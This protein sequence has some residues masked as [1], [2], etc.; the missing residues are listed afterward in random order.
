VNDGQYYYWPGCDFDADMIAALDFMRGASGAEQPFFCLQEPPC[1]LAFSIFRDN[2]QLSCGVFFPKPGEEWD[3]AVAIDEFA[4][5]QSAA[6]FLKSR[7]DIPRFSIRRPHIFVCPNE[8]GGYDYI[9][10]K[11]EGGN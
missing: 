7:D 11:A 3:T 5:G 6:V 4:A 10:G 2:K 1:K 9:D 8:D